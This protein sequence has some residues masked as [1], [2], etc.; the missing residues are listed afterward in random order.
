MYVHTYI[1]T[2]TY[3]YSAYI[4]MHT[5]MYV[6]MRA[7]SYIYIYVG[8]HICR[9][10]HIY[11]H[12]HVHMYI[13]IRIYVYMVVFVYIHMPIHICVHIYIHVCVYVYMCVCIRVTYI[14][15]HMISLLLYCAIAGRVR[16]RFLPAPSCNLGGPLVEKCCCPRGRGLREYRHTVFQNA[17]AM[18]IGRQYVTIRLGRPRGRD[19]CMCRHVYGLDAAI[20]VTVVVSTASGSPL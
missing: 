15:M 5:H 12:V 3:K 2:Y 20:L 4:Y 7:Y 9:H 10:M 16:P 14:H 8:I 6:N 11:I 13:R 17:Y 1:H 18:L 19:P